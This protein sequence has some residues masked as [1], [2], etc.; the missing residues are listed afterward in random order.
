MKIY[1]EQCKNCLLSPDSIVSPARRKE[2][3]Q[4]CAN[5][6]T[7]FSCHKST[8]AGS[9]IC[10]KKFFDDFGHVSQ[11]IR[12]SERLGMIEFVPQTDTT[13]LISY[14]EQQLKPTK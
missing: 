2:L 7:H 8:I 3:L 6:Q 13:K 12:I 10:C 5:E 9:D 14:R 4:G 1:S 11:M